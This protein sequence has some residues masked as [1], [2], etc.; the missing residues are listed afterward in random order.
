[1][2]RMQKG[3]IMQYPHTIPAVFLS[4]PNRFIAKVLLE[5]EEVICH[6]KNTGRCREILLPGAK[7]YLTPGENPARKTPYDLVAACKGN[8]II[9]IDSQAPNK[10]AG[11]FLR[12]RF[13]SVRAE[14]SYGR[15]RMDFAVDD[16]EG[17][18]WIEVKGVTLENDGVVLFPDAPTERGVKHLR[19][20]IHA[21]KEGDRAMLL[22]V[23]Q[24]SDVLYFTPNRETDPLFA[25][26]L[27][28]AA[29]AGVIIE[30]RDCVVTPDSMTLHQP[31]PVKL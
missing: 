21:V 2:C 9:N 19:E 4:R 6:V 30:A 7:V 17:R 11:E 15:S 22:L 14:V 13:P 3:S 12:S 25:K 24:M 5:G 23:V 20:L 29:A 27:E 16:A 28:E 31:I 18:I 1:M 26:T 8:R 10:A